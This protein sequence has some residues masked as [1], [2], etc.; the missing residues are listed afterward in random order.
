[1]KTGI[2]VDADNTCAHN[3]LE[4][5]VHSPPP[6][7]WPSIYATVELYHVDSLLLAKLATSNNKSAS[8]TYA[9]CNYI[10]VVLHPASYKS[11]STYRTSR[12][13]LV[14]NM[15]VSIKKV[16]AWYTFFSSLRGRIRGCCGPT[17]NI[18]MINNQN[19]TFLTE[20]FQ[21]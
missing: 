16:V 13:M 12:E 6:A 4:S 1:M 8:Q 20:G 9:P 2:Y 5:F 14:H 3:L 18:C 10:N 7:I 15:K 19:N 17:S 21:F 11:S